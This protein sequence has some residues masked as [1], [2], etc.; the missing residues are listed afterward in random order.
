MI[1]IR[2]ITNPFKPEEAEL[3][4]ILLGAGLKKRLFKRDFSDGKVSVD[5]RESFS[6]NV[7][8][9]FGNYSLCISAENIEEAAK[10][11]NLI[12]EKSDKMRFDIK[13]NLPE[14]NPSDTMGMGYKTGGF[15]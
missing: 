2:N 5:F 13:S 12:L 4:K 9:W 15:P 8:S 3:K 11:Y 1:I 6:Y 14:S 7:Y 10:L